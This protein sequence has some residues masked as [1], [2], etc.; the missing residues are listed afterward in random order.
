M[1]RQLAP[2]VLFVYNRP[3]HTKQ[4]LDALMSNELADQSKLYIFSDG[5]K[6]IASDDQM[7]AIEEVRHLIREKQWCREVEIIESDYNKGLADSIIHGVTHIVN[8]HEKIIVLEDDL[9]TSKGFL[10]FMNETLNMYNDDE[11]VMH[12]SGY[13][14]PVNSQIS[15]TTFFLKILSCWG[16]GTW[17]RAWEY[18]N[19]NVKDHIKY[20]SQSKELLRKFDIEGHAYFYKQ[21]L[22]N[23]DHKIYSWAVR[24]YAS[25][26]RAGGYSLFPKMSL[27]KNIGFDGSGIHCDSI[28]MYDVNPV[29][30]LPVKKIDVV[31]NKTIRKEFDRFFERSLTRKISH[32]NRVKSLIR[33][34]G[35]RQAKHVM[36]R[37]LIRLFPEI[38]DL[39]SSNEGIG[40]IRSFKRNTKTG[41]YVRTMSPY[42]LSDCVIGDYTY[43]AGNSWVSKTRIGKFCSIG[44]QL[45]CGWGIHPVD[46]VSTHPMFYSTQKQNGMTLSNIDKVQERKEISIGNDVFIGMR[47]TILDGVKIGDGAII[48]A[49]SIV[50]KDVPPYAIVAGSPMRIIRYR[51]SEEMIN[52]LLSIRW[53]DFPDDR[54]R[55][56]EELIFDV[57]RFIERST[58]NSRK[59]YERKILPN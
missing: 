58:K 56:V 52:S 3:R 27:V 20:F 40:T 57:K 28:S 49:G 11:R 26:L 35:G 22:D 37:L 14:Y 59:D 2:I 53:W 17:K 13:M 42:H 1:H 55:D 16:W 41:R 50:S 7:R 29:E 23:A 44:P 43:I 54:L 31:E 39:V 32:K 25:W 19:H 15:Q 5:P 24:W 6:Y 8:K 36:R 9:V 10:K 18:Y 46:S 45:L 12:V 33:K 38:R 30:S 21:L 51:F 34:Y 4:I 47:V 48:G